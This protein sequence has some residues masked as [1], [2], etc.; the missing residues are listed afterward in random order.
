[1]MIRGQFSDFFMGTMLPALNAKIWQ[2][3]R[4]K[5]LMYKRLYQVETSTRS[6]E[7]HSQVSGVGLMAEI[8]E[9]GEVRMD[10]P[11]QG[12]DALFT[13]RKYGLGIETSRDLVEDDKIGLVRRG[14]VELGYSA[15]ETIEWDAAS[16]FNN[17]FSSSFAG[18]DGQPLCSLNHP[19]LKA[20]GV[21]ANRLSTDADLDVDSLELALTDW[22][23][24]RR[25]NGHQIS[26][27]TPRLLVPPALR[28]RGHELL[29]GK[30]RSDTANNTVN[31][32]QY[33]ESGAVDEIMVWSKLTDPDAWFLVAPPEHTGLVWYW[34]VKPYTRGFFDDKTERG[35]TILRYRKSQGFTDFYGVFGSPGA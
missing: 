33:G 20:G 12:F 5:P 9:T 18:P 4:Q 6:I 30:L 35:G 8:P 24:M 31:A 10:Q 3:F 13:H 14:A 7:Q 11:V 22:E 27:P 19:L 1:M 29:K 2:S 15:N 23:T 26:L 21:Q 25:S 34:R 28:W 17:A 32:F 16:T